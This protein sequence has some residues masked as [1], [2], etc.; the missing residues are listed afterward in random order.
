[1]RLLIP[2]FALLLAGC[3]SIA[4]SATQ[5]MADALTVA[6][7]NQNDI[8][9]V[10]A[11]LPAY[12]LLIGGMAQNN[13]DDASSQIAA[14]QLHSLYGGLFAHNPAR[15]QRLTKNALDYG[16]QGLS[17]SSRI[18]QTAEELRVL[19]AR[20]F[21]KM[22]ENLNNSDTPAL[23]ATATAWLGWIQVNAGDWN[24]IGDLAKARLMLERVLEL[25]PTYEN[26]MPH[27]YLGVLETVVP[28]ATGGRPDKAK[29]HF[30][31]ARKLSDGK[32]LMIDV[33]YAKHYAR[34]IF[35]REL[36]DSLLQN[37]LAADP[38]TK[39]YVLMNTLAQQEAQQLMV[40]SP[41]YFE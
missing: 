30:E 11:G 22:L 39:D 31:Q 36:H 4:S 24:A 37:V 28:P 27:V 35:D 14:A 5:S 40:D 25:N 21:P 17:L 34:I 9:T 1:M 41:R 13:P 12:L 23:Y 2:A 29:E 26:G 7:Q 6:V 10:E 15:A 32:N 16:L 33:L 38:N 3:G 8:E 20:D 18:P 19:P